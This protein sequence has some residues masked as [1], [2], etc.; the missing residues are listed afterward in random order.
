MPVE[1]AERLESR[2]DADAAPEEMEEIEDEI[3]SGSRFSLEVSEIVEREG[4]KVAVEVRYVEEDS[5]KG[6][7]TEGSAE[8]GSVC[9]SS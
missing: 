2:R 7:S 6:G 8:E 3:A 4:S 1:T 9:R 5:F